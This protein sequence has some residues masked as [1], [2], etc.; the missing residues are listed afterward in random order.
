MECWFFYKAWVCEGK[1]KK[2]DLFMVRVQA[3]YTCFVCIF[4]YLIE[5]YCFFYLSQLGIV[6]RVEG[7]VLC[8]DERCARLI[9]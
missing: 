6:P 4:I 1:E 3:V 5:M 7:Y 2:Q 9:V 8:I